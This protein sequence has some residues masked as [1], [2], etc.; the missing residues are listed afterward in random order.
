[1]QGQAKQDVPLYF[2]HLPQ[3]S[4][5]SACLRPMHRSE[6]V[7]SIADDGNFVKSARKV[8]VDQQDTELGF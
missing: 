4:L 1:M 3:V 5:R 8:L 7:R 2:V 6:A